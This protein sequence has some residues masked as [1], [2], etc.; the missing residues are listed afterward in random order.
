MDSQRR[1]WRARAGAWAGTLMLAAVAIIVPIGPA[2]AAVF[3]V[4]PVCRIGT[5]G[6]WTYT[7]YGDHNPANAVDIN[8]GSGGDDYRRKVVASAYGTLVAKNE[9]GG[10]GNTLT[11][12]H[13]D[14]TYSFYAHL[15]WRTA[16]P[17]GSVVNKGQWIASIGQTGTSADTPHL[18]Y[19]QRTSLNGSAIR[20]EIGGNQIAYYS[21]RH[22]FTPQT[23]CP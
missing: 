20:V 3:H 11:I 6:G 8:W 23:P 21:S 7:T 18:H 9:Y 5:E 10:Y 19:E 22:S 16:L 15:Y 4:W 2:H 1:V 13:S 17:V 12:K 14:G